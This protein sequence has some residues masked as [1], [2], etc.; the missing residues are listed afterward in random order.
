MTKVL[1]LEDESEK[2]S[3][4]E[5][6]VRDSLNDDAN[7]ETVGNFSAFCA[8][9][10]QSR[11]D[12]V[13]LDL[14]VP[15]HA[16]GEAIDITGEVL[17]TIR[18]SQTNAKAT[19]VAITKY[20]EITKTRTR[21]LAGM[22]IAL[23]EFSDDDHW[24][25]ALNVTLQRVYR[26]QE[27]DFIILCALSLERNAFQSTDSVIGDLFSRDGLNCQ[28]LKIGNYSG[29]AILLQRMGLVEASIATAKAIENFRP[30]LVGTSGICAAFESN[31]ALGSIMIGN[32]VWEHQAGKWLGRDFA[33]EMYQEAL[34]ERV[35]TLIEQEIERTNNFE[36]LKQD[37]AELNGPEFFQPKAVV[38]A[39]VSGSAVIASKELQ[40]SIL[41]QHKRLIGLDMEMFGVY[42]AASKASERIDFFGVKVAVDFA[43]E[44]KNKHYQLPAAVVSAR[45]S[46]HLIPLLLRESRLL[47]KPGS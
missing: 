31:A 33:V 5:K 41:K 47:A 11:F 45:V 32:P 13:I 24:L 22:G 4:I 3:R 36:H 29:V 25:P 6:V 42:R 38:G 21:E 28:A 9:L 46:A 27:Y 17:E 7:V 8:L 10:A 37:L 23:V 14:M 44:N 19:Y 18:S 2:A 34:P 40:E 39:M 15:L 1:M 16:G 30:K 35:V 20:D 26:Y 43:N 12:L